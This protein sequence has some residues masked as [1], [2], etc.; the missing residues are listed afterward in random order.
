MTS[1]SSQGEFL[2]SAFFS[3][4]V[5]HISLFLP[6]ISSDILLDSFNVI[7]IL[8]LVVFL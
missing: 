1:R 2:L 6:I 4:T 5:G 8:N 3:L 7:E